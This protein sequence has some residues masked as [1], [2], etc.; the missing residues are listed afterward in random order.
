MRLLRSSQ[1]QKH[2]NQKYLLK[3]KI[4]NLA[5]IEAV[6]FFAFSVKKIQ[7]DSVTKED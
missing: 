3:I 2:S 6:S 7:A 4:S 5:P 1:R